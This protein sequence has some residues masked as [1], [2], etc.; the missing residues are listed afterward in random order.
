M[1]STLYR[2]PPASIVPPFP[3]SASIRSTVSPGT[4]TTTAGWSAPADPSCAGAAHACT[5][6]CRRRLT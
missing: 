4:R 2:R 1:C 6:A 5:L 3:T